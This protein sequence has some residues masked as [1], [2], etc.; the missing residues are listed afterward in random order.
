M[1]QI[2][3]KA[4]N[5]GGF[6]LLFGSFDDIMRVLYNSEFAVIQR[7]NEQRKICCVHR[8]QSMSGCYSSNNYTIDRNYDSG[9]CS[10]FYNGGMGAFDRMTANAVYDLKKKYPDIKNYLVILY[11]NFKVHDRN[12]FDEIILPSGEQHESNVYYISAIPKRNRYMV[13]HAGYALCYVSG[14]P[15]GA[16]DTYKYAQEK[17]LKLFNIYNLK[18][19]S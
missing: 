12:I 10:L 7:S 14:A 11:Q 1:S 9:R 5:A 18:S 8:S 3:Q 4:I 6:L 2:I 19:N 17:G 15:G 16:A 13:D